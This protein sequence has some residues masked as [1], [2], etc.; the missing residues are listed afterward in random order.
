MRLACKSV[1]RL[2]IITI[3]SLA[4]IDRF[5]RALN[6]VPEVNL[7]RLVIL[8]LASPRLEGFKRCHGTPTR[9]PAVQHAPPCI[10]GTLAEERGRAWG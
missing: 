5:T 7:G 2:Q 6:L 9:V 8:T 10:Q 3:I 1:L 4:S